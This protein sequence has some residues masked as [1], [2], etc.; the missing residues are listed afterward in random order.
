MMI[1]Y[2]FLLQ[3][4]RFAADAVVFACSFRDRYFRHG[5]IS[6]SRAATQA[7]SFL[8]RF[9]AFDITLSPM[10]M[11]RRFRHFSFHYID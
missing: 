5:F 9:A 7:I 8:L 4:E 6:F 3:A 2:A 11:I 10:P 1:F